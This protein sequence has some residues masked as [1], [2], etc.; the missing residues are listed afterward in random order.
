MEKNQP[1]EEYLA[2]KT[3]MVLFTLAEELYYEGCVTQYEYGMMRLVAHLL[4]QGKTD[5]ER[6]KEVKKGILSL[7]ILEEA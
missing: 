4:V 2:K 7:Q 3:G 6:M 5:A 1:K